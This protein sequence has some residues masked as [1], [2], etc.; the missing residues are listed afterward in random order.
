M[1]VN[2]VNL[3]TQNPQNFGKLIVTPETIETMSKEIFLDN[4]KLIDE[5]KKTISE[6]AKNQENNKYFDIQLFQGY[7][8]PA[9]NTYPAIRIKNKAG[10]KIFEFNSLLDKYYPMSEEKATIEMLKDANRYTPSHIE[11]YWKEK[12]KDILSKPKPNTMYLDPIKNGI[13]LNVA[14]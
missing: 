9:Q 6:V 13:Y 14:G 5:F 7:F 10:G 11:K 2:N 12:A 8:L 1:K 4:K 3:R